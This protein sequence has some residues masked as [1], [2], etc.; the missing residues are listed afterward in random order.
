MGSIRHMVC[1]SESGVYGMR[2]PAETRTRVTRRPSSVSSGTRRMRRDCQVHRSRSPSGIRSCHWGV[3]TDRVSSIRP[4]RSRRLH[5]GRSVETVGGP[6]GRFSSSVSYRV[7]PMG[8]ITPNCPR[9]PVGLPVV[10]PAL[11]LGSPT[12]PVL[13]AAVSQQWVCRSQC[14]AWGGVSGSASPSVREAKSGT[15]LPVAAVATIRPAPF[16]SSLAVRSSAT[17]PNGC[18]GWKRSSRSLYVSR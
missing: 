11:T 16:V 4:A 2:S 17:W 3:A 13:M 10:L 6:T 8:R 12:A 5:C 14:T 18:S 7:D 1:G 15:L 9:G